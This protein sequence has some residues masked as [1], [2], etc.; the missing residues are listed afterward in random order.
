MGDTEKRLR[1]CGNGY[2]GGSSTVADAAMVEALQ[3][4]REHGALVDDRA[5]KRRLPAF[6]GRS[7]S[8][9]GGC[10]ASR[11]QRTGRTT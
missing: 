3:F 5:S 10:P 9:T 6:P 7:R 2:H 4:L 8:A 11:T 1:F